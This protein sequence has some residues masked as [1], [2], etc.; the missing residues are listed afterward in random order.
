[1]IAELGMSSAY[2]KGAKKRNKRRWNAALRA[3]SSTSEQDVQP[4]KKAE[5]TMPTPERLAKGAF[6]VGSGRRV[7]RDKDATPLRRALRFKKITRRQ[8]EAGEWLEAAHRIVEGSQGPRSCLDDSVRGFG[9]TETERYVRAS[10]AL[11]QVR[12]LLPA[13]QRSILRSVCVMHHAI[14]DM[15]LDRRRYK[16]LF[17]GLWALADFRD[18]VKRA[19]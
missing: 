8:M 19:A 7:Y 4:H 12:A 16:A 5:S 14:G 15:R 18:G 13:E 10:L 6:E 3:H 1:M 11:D 2:T 9:E 17:H